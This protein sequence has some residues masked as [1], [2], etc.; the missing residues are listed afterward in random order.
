MARHAEGNNTFVIVARSSFDEIRAYNERTNLLHT[1]LSN[2]YVIAPI[3]WRSLRA[4]CFGAI[5]GNWFTT[6][7]TWQIS[8]TLCYKLYGESI[9]CAFCFIFRN[10]ARVR[11]SVFR[12]TVLGISFTKQK[13]RLKPYFMG[14]W[15]RTNPWSLITSSIECVVQGGNVIFSC[16][17]SLPPFPPFN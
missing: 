11:D 12:E 2:S 3:F 15:Q 6:T 14:L 4:P 1:C 16:Y 7:G 13:C 5:F 17:F 10:H 9:S 8:R